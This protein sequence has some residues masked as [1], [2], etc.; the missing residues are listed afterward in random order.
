MSHSPLKMFR[1][2]HDKKVLVT[3]QGPVVDIAKGLGFNDVIT[4]D[5]IR[6]IF[7]NL[8]MVDHKRRKSAVSYHNTKTLNHKIYI[9]TSVFR[10]KPH[11]TIHH[12]YN[13]YGYPNMF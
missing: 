1:Q 9:C 10:C 2:F 5:E 11:F 12:I 13:V 7:T 3:G 8:D 6:H 4:V